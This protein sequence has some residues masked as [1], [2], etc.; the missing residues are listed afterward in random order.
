MSAKWSLTLGV[1]FGLIAAMLAFFKLQSI[2]EPVVVQ[3]DFFIKLAPGVSLAAGERLNFDSLESVEIPAEFTELTRIAVPY[4]SATEAWFAENNVR[5]S[6]D[7]SEGAFVLHEHLIDDPDSRFATVISEKSRAISIPV[8][9]ASAVSYFIQPGSRVDLLVTFEVEYRQVITEDTAR[10]G[11]SFAVQSG[12][13]SGDENANDG[14]TSGNFFTSKK[15]EE[16]SVTRTMLQNM[17][18]LAVGRATTRNSYLNTD[19]YSTVT[20][21]VTPEEAELLTFL[22]SENRGVF[23]LVLRNPTDT[24]IA[25]IDDV[26]WDVIQSKK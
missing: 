15:A 16:R 17:L 21:D 19:G 1:I 24:E 12:A 23:N 22:M 18:V 20:L 4:T 3:G 7:I 5:V 8:S 25:E 11:T 6:Q 10:G 14:Q 9:Q 26:D 2:D 13:R